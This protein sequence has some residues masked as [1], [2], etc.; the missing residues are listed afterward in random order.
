M[1]TS[2]LRNLPPSL[3]KARSRAFQFAPLCMIFNVKK[4]LRRKARIVI[5]ENVLDYSGHEVYAGTIKLVMDRIISPITPENRLG[6]ITG[7]IGNT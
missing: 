4:D 7:D 2:G 1:P 5:G 3:R 6:V